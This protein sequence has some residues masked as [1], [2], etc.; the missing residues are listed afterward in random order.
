MP[1][2]TL[3]A[4]GLDPIPLAPAPSAHPGPH[5]AQRTGLRVHARRLGDTL[6]ESETTVWLL[7]GTTV[8]LA[9]VATAALTLLAVAP[10]LLL[11]TLG[12]AHAGSARVLQ[13]LV[14]LVLWLC[15]MGLFASAWCSGLFDA[16]LRS[17]TAQAACICAIMT[18]AGW[19][20]GSVPTVLPSAPT[21]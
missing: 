17:R 10:N 13:A 12:P 4:P 21:F 20:G 15:L 5:R 19:L 9:L 1:T 16:M 11:G 2:P 8:M 6:G 3:T 14:G 7:L 18:A